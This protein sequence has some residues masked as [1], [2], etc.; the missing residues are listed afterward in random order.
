MS[1][2]P[3]PYWYLLKRLYD[4]AWFFA[5]TLFL[6]LAIYVGLTASKSESKLIIGLGMAASA[7]GVLLDYRQKNCLRKR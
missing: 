7:I 6:I 3:Y 4:I 1:T 2:E 5:A